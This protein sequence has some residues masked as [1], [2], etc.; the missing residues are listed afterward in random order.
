M[1]SRIISFV[2]L[3]ILSFSHPAHADKVEASS[4]IQEVTVFQD[5]ALITRWVE[6]D[7]KAGNHQIRFASLP[8]DLEQDSITAKGEGTAMVELSGARV[9]TI[10][11]KEAAS[12]KVQN[13]QNQIEK[14]RDERLYLGN[15]NKVLL[16]KRSFLESIKAASSDQIGKDLITRQPA[17]E[18]VTRLL[19]LLGTELSQNYQAELENQTA[20]REIDEKI[21]QLER[22][23]SELQGFGARQH[24]NVLVDLKVVK[25]GK[26]SLAVS[27]RVP[28]AQWYPV[29]EARAALE[30]DKVQLISYGMIRQN[31]G[32]DWNQVKLQLST[33]KPAVE[34]R[35]PELDPWFLENWQ[36]PVPMVS[37]ELGLKKAKTEMQAVNGD[38]LFESDSE[39]P[40]NVPVP[41]KAMLSQAEI[42]SS[43]PAVLYQLTQPESILSD[44]QPKKVAI[45]SFD[46][47]S[48]IAHE[49]TPKLSPFVYLRAKVKNDSEGLLLPGD[50]SIF[51]EGAFV[52]HSYLKVTGSGESFDLYLGIDE[53]IRVERK[54]VKAK[55][56]VTVIP[57][58]HGQIKTIDYAF[59]I[60]VEN[61]LSKEANVTVIDQVPISNHDEIKIENISLDPKPTEEVKDKP[62]VMNWVL[63]IPAGQKQKIKIA[64]RVKHPV[65]FQVQGL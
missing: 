53:R 2:F 44:W 51:L 29:Y 19:T 4:Q 18:E 60:T 8:A 63:K 16:Q 20:V 6:L 23:L 50:I 64:Y 3:S 11:L 37:D 36:P 7:L 33:A 21:N 31:T 12:E 45:Q 52:G 58:F 32:E 15:E 55:V 46:L 1:F 30:S 13:L 42:Q 61:Y 49:T 5:R 38:E 22:E 47:P 9:E 28:N 14:L 34:G 39:A 59:V 40:L 56:D 27:Y 10:Q 62:G 48:E 25:E 17:A 54:Q 41:E 57:G 35:M 26:L 65:S 43:G 24:V